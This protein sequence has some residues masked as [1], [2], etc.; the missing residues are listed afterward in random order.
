MEDPSA[1]IAQC[2]ARTDAILAAA[3][4]FGAANTHGT[5]SKSRPSQAQA[6]MEEE[7]K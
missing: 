5:R 2:E 7:K 6:K 1:M 4:P 3:S